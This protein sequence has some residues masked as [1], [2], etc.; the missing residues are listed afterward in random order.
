MH[1]N[2]SISKSVTNTMGAVSFPMLGVAALIW[3]GFSIDDAIDKGK[4]LISKI[5]DPISDWITKSGMFQYTAD[6]L[7]R[8]ILQNRQR[9]ED[10]GKEYEEYIQS[11]QGDPLEYDAHYNDGKATLMRQK[12]QAYTNRDLVLRKMLNDIATGKGGGLGW[13]STAYSDSAA[14]EYLQ[15]EYGSYYES[16]QEQNELNQGG[17]QGDDSLIAPINWE[18]DEDPDATV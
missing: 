7:G 6:E 13:L 8:A 18:I 4:T 17:G 10:L 11:Y 9:K 16:L 3:V 5:A 12:L 2:N 15:G 14:S 1:R